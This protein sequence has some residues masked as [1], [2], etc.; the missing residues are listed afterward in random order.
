M[1]FSTE[2]IDE[3]RVLALFNLDSVNSGI[4]AHSA[5]EPLVLAAISRL[6]A[7]GLI[8]QPDGGYLTDLGIHC[9]EQLQTAL[10]ILGTSDAS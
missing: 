1:Q 6:Y 10:R 7:K 5:A 2:L 9:A 8:N 4:K 3:M